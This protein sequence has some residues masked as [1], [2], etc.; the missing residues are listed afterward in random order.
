MFMKRCI[1]LRSERMREQLMNIAFVGLGRMGS[2][3][4]GN[5]LQAGHPLTVFNRTQGKS[6]TLAQAGAKVADSVAEAVRGCEAVFTMLADDAAVAD[7]V[8]GSAGI[9]AS[10]PAGAIH[11]SM[12]TISLAT[13]RKLA[14][15]HAAHRQVYISAPVFGRP[16][17]AEAKRLLVVAAGESEAI[18]RVRDLLDA[19][20]RHT[21]VAGTEA[22]QANLMKLNGNFMIGCIMETFGEAFATIRKAGLDHHLFYEIMA[23]LFGSPVY[24]GYGAAIANET[25]E[26]A[27]FALKLGLKDIRLGLEAASEFNV[28][29]PFASVL[30]D[31]LLAAMA[32]GQEQQDWSSVGMVAARNG[33][34]KT[35]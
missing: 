16:D 34:V 8:F 14:Q 32:N 6:E 21:Y 35:K 19:V 12:S 5:L 23:E 31:Q 3:I 11:V 27:G 33:G 25:F 22:W 24:K 2:A 20:G 7:V 4:A 9:A 13:A 1:M 18:E 17:S 29:M 28:P 30:R 10:L 26:P 15:E